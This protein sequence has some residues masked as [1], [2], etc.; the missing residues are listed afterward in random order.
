MVWR[1][2]TRKIDFQREKYFLLLILEKTR[3]EE[4]EYRLMSE[5]PGWSLEAGGLQD[6]VD[7][8]MPAWKIGNG[9]WE[10]YIVMS[11]IT[12]GSADWYKAKLRYLHGRNGTEE[13][14]ERRS[15]GQGRHERKK[16]EK[17][18]K[19]KR[20]KGQDSIGGQIQEHDLVP[21]G[22]GGVGDPYSVGIRSNDQ[23]GLAWV[24][25]VPK[26]VRR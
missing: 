19:E 8:W 22:Q 9:K 13:Y 16:R 11:M 7:R 1:H 3:V 18:G 2:E 25:P 4:W 12:E 23:T 10:E 6:G 14:Y 15:A 21:G 5:P 17:N 24:Q 20:K 26:A